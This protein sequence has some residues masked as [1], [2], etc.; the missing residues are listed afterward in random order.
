MNSSQK[1]SYFEDVRARAAGRWEQ[2]KR[3]PE[4]AA[5]WHQ[6]FKQVQNPRHVLSELLQNADDAGA[7]EAT[8]DILDGEFV[9]SHNGEDFTQEHFASLC[10]FGY[11]NKR[12]LHTIGFRGIGFKSTFS[13]GD[14][15]RL[16]TPTL[17]VCYSH[18][19]FTE[20]VWMDL[21]CPH[22]S[23]TEVR[24]AIKDEFLQS[25][26]EK[27]LDEWIRSPASLLFF[28]S[29]RKLRIRDSEVGWRSDG[30][31]PST[32]SEW[33]ALSSTPDR[34]YLLIRSDLE[35]FPHEA[36][37]EIRQERMVSLDEESSF[38]PCRLE[39]VLGMEGRFFVILPTEVR[40]ELPFACNAPFMQ[41]PARTQ[42]KPPETSPTN[43]WLLRRA[44]ELAASAMLEWLSN[45]RMTKEERCKAYDLLPE[46]R[47][48]DDDSLE[49]SCHDI[50]DQ[51]MTAFVSEEELLLA[52]S[53]VL[54][55]SQGCE[56][57][58]TPLMDV[59]SN[60]QL[61]HFFTEDN[62]PVLCRSV[63]PTNQQKLGERELV[64]MVDYDD[65]VA[66]LQSDQL[67]RPESWRQLLTL[68]SFLA[69]ELT[70]RRMSWESQKVQII[71][72]QGRNVL[73]AANETVRLGERKL[74]QSEDDWEF[75]ASRL[76]I[77][78]QNWPRFLAEQRRI[79]EER[80]D[81]ALA[82]AV[83]SAYSVLEELELTEASSAKLVIEKFSEDIFHEY[84]DDPADCVR[85]A[86]IAACL[87]VPVSDD[88]QYVTR[89][90]FLTP[91]SKSVVADTDSNV[92]FFVDDDWYDQYVLHDEY[93]NLRSCTR[94]E[95]HQWVESGRSKLHQF[96]PIRNIELTEK[97]RTRVQEQL[98][99]RGY[100]GDVTF[101][102]S[103]DHFV[104]DDWDF[105]EEH[106]EYWRSLAE[107]DESFWERLLSRILEQ[108]A[109]FWFNSL[110]TSV[111]QL[112]SNRGTKKA[113]TS[114]HVSSGWIVKFRG[115]P[116][117]RDTRGNL[118]HPAELL[119]RTAET[120]PLLDVEPF[121]RAEIDTQQNRPLLRE[122]GVR[123][124]P[125]GSRRLLDRVRALAAV[126]DPPVYEVEKWYHGLDKLVSNCSTEEQASIKAAF[127]DERLILTADADWTLSSEVFL[128]GDEEDVPGAALIHP[129]V[130][131][132]AIWRRV[133]IAERPTTDLAI[134][135][136]SGLESGLELTQDELR[137]VRA[138]LPRHPSL[139]W[140]SCGHWLNLNGEWTPVDQL[141]YALT[142]Q[143]L[144]AWKHL[145]DS[146]KAKTA[147]LQKLPSDTC[148]R[149]PFVRLRRLADVIEERFCD[150]PSRL[151]R[152]QEQ[153]WLR[154]LGVG[155]ARVVLEDSEETDRI[156][157]LADRLRET[158]WQVVD[159]L[160]TVPYVDDE[161]VGT[162]RSAC[163][164]WRESTLYVE[165]RSS[166]R[167]ARV[168]AQELGREFGRQEIID[169]FKICYDRSTSF[170]HE[171]LEENFRLDPEEAIASL[172]SEVSPGEEV[173][174][175]PVRTDS[176]A[177]MPPD[178]HHDTDSPERVWADSTADTTPENERG[179]AAEPYE[180][181]TDET[182]IPQDATAFGTEGLGEDELSSVV[183]ARDGFDS[184]ERENAQY[185]RRSDKLSLIERFA[186]REGY[187]SDANGIYIHPH[188]CQIKRAPHGSSCFPWEC[189]SSAGE[190]LK[191]YWHK[192]HCIDLEPMEIDADVWD[193]CRVQPE[194]YSLLLI[195]EDHAPLEITG[196]ELRDMVDKRRLRL[197]PAKYRLACNE[198]EQGGWVV[199][200]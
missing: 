123:D 49:G 141:T 184:P 29:L 144:V 118:R 85:L 156:R 165:D 36:L 78:N 52:E 82:D 57:L 70:A 167:T 26:L 35:D 84:D 55:P 32:N 74:L 199:N 97:R 135:W 146:V 163:A 192:E 11:S 75:L 103:R 98:A 177:E 149:E 197:Y 130:R 170:V 162:R 61:S 64:R 12:A 194:K 153:P 150:P 60:D 122:L 42:I 96:V 56:C 94:D 69:E 116:C 30:P 161:P 164:V 8:V 132:L 16:L 126:D 92:Q 173:R 128:E 22:P 31:G 83:E 106:W 169:A 185:G 178:E 191:C 54:T 95:W 120:E 88:F 28:R 76:Q 104:F 166:A 33:M 140:E 90:G 41:D 143:T 89:D 68:W 109:S 190:L 46:K 172:Q 131:H 80:D 71:P 171:Y 193:L 133:G 138:L 38:P 72:V 81:N 160:E 21:D 47:S 181:Q 196:L 73:F 127:A 110:A 63:S 99:L 108:R 200:E 34:R 51:R 176:T 17:A 121:V 137:R 175:D 13:L 179:V 102:S 1:P 159:N 188:G 112:S 124:T 157:G 154:A 45:D 152:P 27:N 39:I 58:P 2:L 148:V 136:L 107:E 5:P 48:E 40:T 86:Q 19:R 187:S 3:D 25:Q 180:S 147:D 9:F 198:S 65:V 125:T 59:W 23:V 67:P 43:R 62:A 100:E 79:A 139:I 134:E 158:Q 53:G 113:V 66:T 44:G 18:E 37:D 155:L 186:E 195:D 87:G 129:S 105:Y 7:T 50:V 117:L 183:Q 15:V 189:W 111:Y 115:L 93:G 145:F 91:A 142:M 14:E 114:D 24:V 77:L 151:V 174:A 119:C 20:P 168:A 6:L 101:H 4:L 10:R 182:A